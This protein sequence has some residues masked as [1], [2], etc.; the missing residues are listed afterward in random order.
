[1]FDEKP[2]RGRIAPNLLTFLRWPALDDKRLG[3]SAF[4]CCPS[5]DPPAAAEPEPEPESPVASVSRGNSS[6]TLAAASFSSSAEQK[7]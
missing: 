7:R 2:Q 3:F 4:R 1:M 5:Q 6:F